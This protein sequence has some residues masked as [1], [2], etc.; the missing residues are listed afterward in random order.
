MLE[1]QNATELITGK[2]AEDYELAFNVFYTFKLPDG[3]EMSINSYGDTGVVYVRINKH[4]VNRTSGR[5]ELQEFETFNVRE[6]K[7]RFDELSIELN[8]FHSKQK[9]EWSSE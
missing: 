3:S 7:A 9:N 4:R 6:H 8:A 1:L 5:S 2:L